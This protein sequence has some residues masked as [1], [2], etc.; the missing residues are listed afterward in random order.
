MSRVLTVIPQTWGA[1]A[2]EAALGAAQ[3]VSGAEGFAA[4]LISSQ[5]SARDA[6]CAMRAGARQVYQCVQAALGEC[7]EPQV[8]VAAIGEALRAIPRLGGDVPLVLLPPGPQGEE[9][10]ALLAMVSMA[11]RW[12]AAWPWGLT[13]IRCWRNARHGVDACA[14]AWRSPVGQPS[15]ACAQVVRG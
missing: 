12:G 5:P 2:L 8:L 9:L 1:Q 14:S 6:E 7:D 13:A 15:P 3:Q 4:V 10:A 11:R